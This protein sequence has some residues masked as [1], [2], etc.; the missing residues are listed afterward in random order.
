MALHSFTQKVLC[1]LFGPKPSVHSTSFLRSK[2]LDDYGAPS[3]RGG[4]ELYN[5]DYCN[6]TEDLYDPL[7]ISIYYRGLMTYLGILNPLLFTLLAWEEPWF[8]PSMAR[9][10]VDMGSFVSTKY[11]DSEYLFDQFSIID[12]KAFIAKT[13]YNPSIRYLTEGHFFLLD[14]SSSFSTLVYV[15]S[16]PDIAA[17][18]CNPLAHY[19]AAGRSEGTSVYSVRELVN[20]DLPLHTFHMEGSNFSLN[21]YPSE[22]DFLAISTTG[23]LSNRLDP[24]ISGIVHGEEFMLPVVAWWEPDSH[25]MAS[26]E[27]LFTVSSLPTCIRSLSYRGKVLNAWINHLPRPN[28]PALHPPRTSNDGIIRII[29][30]VTSWSFLQQPLPSLDSKSEVFQRLVPCSTIKS[31]LDSLSLIKSPVIGIHIRRPYSSTLFSSEETAK[32]ELKV[33]HYIEFSLLLLGSIA[34]LGFTPKMLITSNCPEAE[35]QFISHFSHALVLAKENYDNTISDVAVKD[36][37]RDMLALS[38]CALVVSSDATAFGLLAASSSL[39]PCIQ[40]CQQ[41]QGHMRV[42]GVSEVVSSDTYKIS[43]EN[44]LDI[45]S[46]SVFAPLT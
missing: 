46:S 10:M 43:D 2:R 44:I 13:E 1:D 32:F 17:S 20:G 15:L 38:R 24:I 42:H 37:L 18:G 45:I 34:R 19:L 31:D 35:H 39:K 41:K 3:R 21:N 6:K 40:L 16:R 14:P 8:Y 4:G 30:S 29:Q 36:G 33:C 27:S 26:L 28:Y 7:F 12:A 9:L 11:F 23:G 22:S 25:C 5:I